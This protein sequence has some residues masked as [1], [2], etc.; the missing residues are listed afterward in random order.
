[1]SQQSGRNLALT[2][3]RQLVVDLMHFCQKV[4]GATVERSMNLSPL[5]AARRACVPRPSWSSIFLKAMS[6]VAARRPELRRSFMPF[7]WPHLYEHPINI[8]NFP[9]ERRHNDEDVVLFVQL[10]RAEQRSLAELNEII[11]ACKDQPVESVKFFSR[12][13]RMSKAPWPFRRLAWW[14]SLNLMGKLRCHNFGTFSVSSVA[15][16]GAGVLSLST[17]LTS[18]LHYGLFDDRGNLPM[19]MTFDHRVFDGAFAAR[20]IVELEQ[21]LLT[22]ILE[23]LLSIRAIKAA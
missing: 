4:P 15:G 1:M 20:T 12:A 18:T 14:V 13:I 7:P 9:L 11:Q 19:R 3:F 2:P 17:L 8:A 22:D 16:E 6:I 23:E 5:I 21:V 10:R